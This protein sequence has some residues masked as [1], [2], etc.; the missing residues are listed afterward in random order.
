[1]R[2]RFVILA[3][4]VV[5]VAG[6]GLTQA[7]NKADKPPSVLGDWTG[8]W[9]PFA[10]GKEGEALKPYTAAQKKLDCKVATMPN[11]EWQ[12]TFEGEC[13]RPY[14]YTIK[15]AG[16]Q[17][18]DAVLFKGTTD[19][20]EKDGGVYDWIGR[21]TE[22]GFVGFFTSQNYAGSFQLSRPK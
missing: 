22:K 2:F 20:G 14:K 13:G 21:V 18:G 5:F 16:R 12:A 3:A 15:M 9:G 6:F 10:P 1:M 11:G 17:A 19:L 8:I 4:L 7:T